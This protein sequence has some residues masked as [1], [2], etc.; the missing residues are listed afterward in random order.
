M[1]AGADPI[2]LVLG[3]SLV[4]PATVMAAYWNRPAVGEH[5]LEAPLAPDDPSWD[6]YSV[7]RAAE[8][9]RDEEESK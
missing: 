3:L 1:W 8:P 2:G 9:M 7:W 4:M 6:E 5:E